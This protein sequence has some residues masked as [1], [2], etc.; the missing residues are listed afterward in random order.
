MATLAGVLSRP[1]GYTGVWSWITT[2]DHKR[3]GALYGFTAFIVFLVAGLEAGVMRMQLAR[4][5]STL[6][7]PNVFNQMFTMHATA[8]VFMVIM[9]FSAAFFNLVIPLAIG[10]RD[11]AFPRLNAFS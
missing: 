1:S 10:A 9:P 7:D 8:M 11:V 5:D 3:I 6:V 4:A 2:V